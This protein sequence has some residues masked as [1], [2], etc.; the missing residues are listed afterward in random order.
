MFSGFRGGNKILTVSGGSF[1]SNKKSR[2][3]FLEF[4]QFCSANLLDVLKLFLKPVVGKE[5]EE[6][7]NG[8]CC[9]C[10]C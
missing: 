10:F 6:R 9:C 5:R 1:F 4:L 2:D 8:K 3:N 7:F